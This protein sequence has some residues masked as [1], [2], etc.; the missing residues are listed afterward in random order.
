MK[1]DWKEIWDA[2]PDIFIVSGWEEC[3]I[4]KRK[5]WHLPS[6]F[7]YFSAGDMNLRVGIIACEGAYKEE[8]FLL[9]GILWG[10][11][12]GNG[13]RTVI[14]FVAQEFSP[15]F[16]GALAKLGGTLSAKAVF[17]REKLT[18]SLYPVQEKKYPRSSFC[19][20]LG[21][22]RPQWDFWER[23]INPVAL[24]HLKVIKRYFEELVKRRVRTVF[25]KNKIVFCWGNIEIAEVKKKGNK[26]ELTTKIKW[27][28]NKSIA[29]KFLK[30]GWVDCSGAINE[31]FRRAINGILELLENMESNGSLDIKDLLA[32][33]LI[34]EGNFAPEFF[35]KYFELP[36]IPK[37][38]N[39]IFNTGDLY[40]FSLANQIK[41]INPILEKP[42][43]R[44]VI[45]LLALTTLEYSSLSNNG[46][47]P[48]FNN[49]WNRKL[50]LLSQPNLIEELRLCRSWLKE[51]ER[52][53]L[54]L[55]PANWKT[56]GLKELKDLNFSDLQ[57]PFF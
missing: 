30:S 18:P 2:N 56:E 24:N 21:E 8:E 43:Q 1:V 27:T 19:A 51:A 13:A 25:K 10:S 17:W 45:T 28:R 31:E 50:Y 16:L 39:H 41:V 11:R 6:Q 26:F 57:E 47:F 3:L 12:L 37:K 54:I 9:G 35:G 32:I 48:Y 42:L 33:K 46:F 4:E 36:W 7:S 14:Y 29:R 23:H 38:R 22:L 15:I 53:P 34:S 44:I 52:Y 49:K 20:E 5:G 55:L 40:F